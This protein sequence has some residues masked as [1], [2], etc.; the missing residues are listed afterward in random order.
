MSA[1][2]AAVR[3]L[4]R[5][6]TCELCHGIMPAGTPLTWPNTPTAREHPDYATW[7]TVNRR[8]THAGDEA[9]GK[10][11]GGFTPANQ[12]PR[13]AAPPQSTLDN[14]P[15]APTPAQT[16]AVVPAAETAPAVATTPTLPSLTSEQIAILRGGGRFPRDASPDE[17]R[18]GLTVADQ[19]GLNVW[20]GQVKFIR[21]RAG[22][23][24]V[25]Y[26]GIDAYRA[27]AERSGHYQGREIKVVWDESVKDHPIRAIATVYRDDR[28][29]PTVEEVEWSEAV[30]Y[31][32][33]GEPTQPWQNMPVTMLRKAAEERALRAAFPLQLSGVYGD[34]EVPGD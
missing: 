28:Q 15:P 13:T 3:I 26:L 8:W 27:L 11:L 17:I 23:P 30:R 24:M 29:H 14:T 21:F 33:K 34:A 1:N 7:D 18:F 20:A 6:Q 10:L 9:C 16:T 19:I 12:L 25:P 4:D 22:E 32:A 2:G 5:E 31:S